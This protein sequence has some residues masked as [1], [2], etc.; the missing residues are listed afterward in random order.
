MRASLLAIATATSLNGWVSINF[1][2]QQR[3][4]RY[5]AHD[6]KALSA[7]PRPAVFF[8]RHCPSWRN[9]RAEACRP[10]SSVAAP[11]PGRRR[12]APARR[13][14]GSPQLAT[15]VYAVSGLMPGIAPASRPPD[16]TR[17]RNG[18][19][20]GLRCL[21]SRTSPIGC[22]SS[23]ASPSS[24]RRPSLCKRPTRWRFAAWRP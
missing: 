22:R 2:A 9:A 15:N 5:A 21:R 8:E 24:L 4:G 19:C 11:Y 23:P 18:Q 1:C 20:P 14:D 7:R 10:T 6:G 12:I 16:R 3:S 13:L 17:L